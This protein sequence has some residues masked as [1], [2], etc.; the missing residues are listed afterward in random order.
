MRLRPLVQF[1][2][3]LVPVFFGAWLVALWMVGVVLMLAGAA[4]AAD[5]VLR[6]PDAAPT[7]NRPM[8]VNALEQWRNSA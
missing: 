2:V 5:A 1:T 3:A 7:A 6:D 4:I 8:S